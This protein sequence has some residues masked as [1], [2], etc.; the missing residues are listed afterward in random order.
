MPS[1]IGRSNRPPSFGRSA[2]ARYHYNTAGWK[3]EVGVQQSS[4]NALFA[5]PYCQFGEA[6]NG[7]YRQPTSEVDLNLHQRGIQ[8]DLGAASN[9]GERPVLFVDPERIHGELER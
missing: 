4:P 6:N 7:K 2:G 9:P 3:L 5:L 1:A 8:S